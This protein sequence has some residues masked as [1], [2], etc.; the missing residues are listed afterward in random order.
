MLIETQCA[1]CAAKA[2]LFQMS[3][4]LVDRRCPRPGSKSDGFA[5]A[6][7]RAD[8]IAPANVSS[9]SGKRTFQNL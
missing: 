6:E 7:Y 1:W 4:R 3:K 8:H 2:D 9:G 5:N